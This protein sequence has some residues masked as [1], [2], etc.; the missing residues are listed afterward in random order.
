MPAGTILRTKN[1]GSGNEAEL[2]TALVEKG[3]GSS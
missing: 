2:A 1:A 3:S